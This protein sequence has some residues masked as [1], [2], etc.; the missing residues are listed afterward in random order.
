MQKGLETNRLILRKITLKDEANLFRLDSDAAVHRYLGNEPVK[1]KEQIQKVIR[2]IQ[3]QYKKNGIGRYAVILK[4]NNEFIGWAGLKLVKE[5]I[6]GHQNYHDIGFRIIRDYWGNGYAT[7]AAQAWV[8]Y[9]FNKLKLKEIFAT[10]HFENGASIK[11]LQKL[12]M[13][14]V[15]TFEMD[16]IPHEWYQISRSE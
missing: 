10:V 9:G 7:E 16:G 6:N 2:F 4:E 11:V 1:T 14:A 5:K 8:D 3:E 15:N 12:D 13:K